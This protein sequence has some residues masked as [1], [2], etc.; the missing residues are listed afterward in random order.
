MYRKPRAYVNT[1]ATPISTWST[2]RPIIFH[3]NSEVQ[4]YLDH[5]YAPF[6][7]ERAYCFAHVGQSVSPFVTFLF[8]INNLRT[9]WSIFLK[10]SPHNRPGQ[11]K[12]LNDFGTLDQRSRSPGSNVPK[13]FPINN[14]R[15][16]WPTFLK[17]C[18]HSYP[19]HQR[20]PIDF[21]SLGQRSRFSNQ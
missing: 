9:L 15:T 7:E 1:K 10:L 20:N 14:S 5:Y 4:R 2:T 6:G 3:L 18:P 17:L 16:T 21:G 8:P 13:S 12:N 11:Q 19:G